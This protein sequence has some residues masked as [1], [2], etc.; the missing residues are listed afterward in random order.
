VEDSNFAGLPPDQ[1]V[2]D[3]PLVI[4]NNAQM[5]EPVRKS[6]RENEPLVWQRVHNLP[7]YVYFNHSIH[8][9]KGIG[10][11]TCHG[12]VDRMPLMYQNGS[13]QM[14]WCLGLPPPAGAL[15]SAAGRGLQTSITTRA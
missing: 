2:H 6:W 9:N 3:L 8:V 7:E 1:N 11:A 13:L 5:L 12:D 14:A 4:W 10:C 15:H